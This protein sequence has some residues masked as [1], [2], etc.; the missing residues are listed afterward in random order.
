MHHSNC[1]IPFLNYELQRSYFVTREVCQRHSDPILMVWALYGE[2]T[3]GR[4]KRRFHS[5]HGELRIALKNVPDYII[6]A[7]VLHNIEV[8]LKQPDFLGPEDDFIDDQPEC[9]EPTDNIC[10][11]S[12]LP[13]LKNTHVFLYPITFIFIFFVATVSAGWNVSISAM[14]FYHFRVMNEHR[15]P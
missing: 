2:H 12:A 8:D 5:L 3:F 1:F 14:N 13:I 15:R 6:A 4:W 9:P 11:S 10:I 7:A